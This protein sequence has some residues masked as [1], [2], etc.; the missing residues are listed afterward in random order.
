M[1]ANKATSSSAFFRLPPSNQFPNSPCRTSSP[2]DVSIELDKLIYNPGDVV[3]GKVLLNLERPLPCDRI[4]ARLF[5][6]ARVFFTEMLKITGPNFGKNRAYEQEVVLVDQQV[7]LWTAEHQQ[8]ERDRNAKST[9]GKSLE[10]ILRQCNPNT[11]RIAPRMPALARADADLA[12][13]KAGKNN[14]SGNGLAVGRH[15]LSFAYKLPL[16]GLHTSFDARNS[17]GSVR[18]HILV[19]AFNNGFNC[20]RRKLLFPIVCPKRLDDAK[21]LGL[22]MEP[23]LE[24]GTDKR[25]LLC[26]ELRMDKRGYVPG[27]PLAG[28]IRIVNN[29]AKSVKWMSLRIVQ[30][31][32]CIATRPDFGTHQSEFETAAMGLP[33]PK[34]RAGQSLTFPIR[35]YVPALVPEISVPGCIE[36]EHLLRLDVG[37]RRGTCVGVTTGLLIGT[38]PTPSNLPRPEHDGGDKSFTMPTIS[39]FGAP[40]LYEEKPPAGNGSAMALL[41]NVPPPSYAQSVAGISL[42]ANE[43][44]EE[45]EP[46][47][48]YMGPLCY[49]YNFGFH[50]DGPETRGGT[51]E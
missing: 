16:D 24:K 23:V 26:V 22:A 25:E 49:H 13:E 39:E 45:E 32:I 43:T 2:Y 19:Q 12:V 38:H 14:G 47:H 36:S 17:A 51:A 6:V 11:I 50:H 8:G 15:Q 46:A 44:N 7:E 4:C 34:I 30:R 20:L 41:E 35:Y 27:E 1:S 37:D 28:N 21:W 31:T 33:V 40:P 3:S 18:Y 9:Q 5:G 42:G 10:E 29:T 48:P